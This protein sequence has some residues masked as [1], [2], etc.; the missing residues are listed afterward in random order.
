M[1]N[2]LYQLIYEKKRGDRAFWGKYGYLNMYE[3]ENYSDKALFQLQLARLK[4]KEASNIN[5]SY[6]NDFLKEITSTNIDAEHEDTMQSISQRILELLNAGLISSGLNPK[7]IHMNKE[8]VKN[9]K[10]YYS[11]YKG[12]LQG[13][14][15]ENV[16]EDS[17]KL[18][19]ELE[20]LSDMIK[21]SHTD[22]RV[23]R[24][25]YAL[26]GL[27]YKKNQLKDGFSDY[28][29]YKAN[30]AEVLMVE[31]LNKHKGWRAIQ[32]GQLYN[33]SQQLL[34]DA[35]VFDGTINIDFGKNFTVTKTIKNS[36][37][38]GQIINVSKLSEFLDL[39]DGLNANESL[40]LDDPLYEKI[41]EIKLFSAQAK[42]GVELQS[43]LNVTKHRNT[44][45]LQQIGDK[46]I[47]EDLKFLYKQQWLNS[48]ASSEMLGM[49]TNYWLS[50]SITMTNIMKNEIYFTKDGFHTASEWMKLYKQMLKFNPI[51]NKVS[52]SLF[53]SNHPYAF[54]SVSS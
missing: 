44:I 24:L 29:Q 1:S 8:M 33:Q 5:F 52:D 3:S 28:K 13:H 15:K 27:G 49:I 9:E 30:E 14:S 16:K 12:Y 25:G 53:I 4:T 34:E 21:S 26:G 6:V 11:V 45:S 18:I 35:F 2:D 39:I 37:K 42:S 22:A 10:G 36:K 54:S 43:L 47:L 38:P 50:K 31:L 41:Q 23:K 32:S 19:K 20:Q 17:L 7:N 40:S 48:N 51:L 46:I